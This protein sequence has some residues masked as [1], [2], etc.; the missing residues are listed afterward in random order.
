MSRLKHDWTIANLNAQGFVT[1]EIDDNVAEYQGIFY[2]DTRM[3]SRYRVDF[4]QLRNTADHCPNG[5]ELFQ[6]WTDFQSSQESLGVSR[7]LRLLPG[8]FEDQFVVENYSDEEQQ[9]IVQL[10]LDADFRDLM[11]MR[12]WPEHHE[13][14]Q[15]QRWVMAD[16]WKCRYDARDGESFEL[17]VRPNRPFD[18]ELGWHIVLAPRKQEALSLRAT[19]V[20]SLDRNAHAGVPDA[21]DWRK[22]FRQPLAD[23]HAPAYEQ[24]VDDILT[25]LVSTSSGAIASAG[26]PK[27]G[28]PY[29]RDSILTAIMLLDRAPSI[30]QNTLRFF[31]GLQGRTIDPFRDEEPGKIIHEHREGELSRRDILPFHSYYGT[32][33]ATPLFLVLLGRYLAKSGDWDLVTELRPNWEA[34]LDW[35]LANAEQNSYGFLAYGGNEHA[36]ANQSWKDSGDSMVHADG[37]LAVAPIAG[38]EVQGYLY[39]AFSVAADLYASLG[40][41]AQSQSFAGKAEAL[42]QTIDDRFWLDEIGTYALAIDGRG[43]PLRVCAS[44]AGH[45]LW[46]GAAQESRVGRLAASLTSGPLWSGWGIRTLADNEIRF[47]PLSYHLGSVWPHDNAIIASGLERYGLMREAR[48]IAEALYD[49]AAASSDLR[50]PELF[51]GHAK[52]PGIPVIAYPASCVPQAWSAAALIYLAPLLDHPAGDGGGHGTERCGA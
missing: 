44:N 37:S 21:S 23:R 15:Q 40:A 29:G 41:E 28:V 48:R 27:F 20:S 18:L 16:G 8:G 52:A 12:N 17:D 51:S 3:L 26:V 7:K 1:G 45:L 36:L 24:A 46:S 39:E 32:V 14:G 19:F 4:S 49:V 9:F 31:A 13:Y 11:G 2:R 33:D 22:H 5:R 50:V 43:E 30:A 34:A 42:Q 38:V 6:F 35:M 25:L 10:E 47:N